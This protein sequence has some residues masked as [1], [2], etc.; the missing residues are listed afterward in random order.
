MVQ[1]CSKAN[2]RHCH[3]DLIALENEIHTQFSIVSISFS[4]A[5]SVK[6]CK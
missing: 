1:N 6:F 4:V 3:T 2:S 5:V